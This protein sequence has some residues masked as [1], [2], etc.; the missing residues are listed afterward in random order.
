MVAR[1]EISPTRTKT[2]LHITMRVPA[3]GLSIRTLVK[4][5]NTIK[6]RQDR[7]P[8]SRVDRGLGPQRRQP[9]PTAR[10]THTLLTAMAITNTTTRTVASTIL[11]E[12]V[13]APTTRMRTKDMP[14]VK[15]R[16]AIELTILTGKAAA[17]IKEID[18]RSSDRH[19]RLTRFHVVP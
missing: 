12:M 2:D 18:V 17:R 13:E 6:V 19:L 8:T 4:D 14:G 1:G 16:R 7:A 9:A 15:I 3:P 5:T 10:V 11:E